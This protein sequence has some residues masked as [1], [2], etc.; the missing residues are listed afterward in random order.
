MD[1]AQKHWQTPTKTSAEVK[2]LQ[3]RALEKLDGSHQELE[4]LTQQAVQEQEKLQRTRAT[5]SCCVPC[6]ISW[7]SLRARL[8]TKMSKRLPFHP[9]PNLPKDKRMRRE[10]DS[11]C[12]HTLLGLRAERFLHCS[13]SRPKPGC[14]LPLYNLILQ[15][16][17]SWHLLAF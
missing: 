16:D 15:A 1:A 7:P 9:N 12:V 10:P 5:S 13:I 4:T 3:K 11:S 6:R 17:S 8:R 14:L 2:R